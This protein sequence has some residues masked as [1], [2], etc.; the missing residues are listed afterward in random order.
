LAIFRQQKAR[1]DHLSEVFKFMR[2]GIRLAGPQVVRQRVKSISYSADRIFQDIIDAPSL[3]LKW[4]ESYAIKVFCRREERIFNQL[5]GGEQMAA[6]IAVRLALMIQMSDLRIL[7]LDEPTANMD[8]IRRD[9]L[10]DRI[11]RLDGLNQM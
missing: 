1:L 3:T 4:D 5:S 8:D 10:A 2:E 11:T 9:K 7:F 6:A